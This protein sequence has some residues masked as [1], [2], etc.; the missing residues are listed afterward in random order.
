VGEERT[1]NVAVSE[2]D[3]DMN[4]GH[5]PVVRVGIWRLF[6]AVRWFRPSLYL[7]DSPRRSVDRELQE[8]SFSI[9]Q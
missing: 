2:P 5:P 1:I 7:I 8:H 6:N 3:I 4:R 9:W